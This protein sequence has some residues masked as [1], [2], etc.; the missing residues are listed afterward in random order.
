PVYGTAVVV[1]VLAALAI[2]L[3]IPPL[4][5]HFR[6]RNIA[7]GSLVL[8]LLFLNLAI[9]VNAIL[10]PT[11]DISIWWT[12][13]G[14]CD[15]EVY[16]FVGSWIGVVGAIACILRGLANVLD[17]KNT[18]VTTSKN[19]RRRKYAMEITVCFGL[20]VIQMAL[21]YIVQPIRYFIYGISGCTPAADNSWPSIVLVALPPV[22]V[23][24]VCAFYACLVLYRLYRYRIDF[25]RL[26][27][28]SNTTRSRFLRL[29]L[30][31]CTLIIGILPVA[32]YMFYYTAVHISMDGIVPYSWSRVH[33]EHW[34]SVLLIPMGGAV[35]PD[36]WCWIGAGIGVFAFFGTGS[37]A[38]D[39][40][41]AWLRRLGFAY[42]MPCLF[43]SRRGSGS[44][45]HS[46]TTT[47][48]RRSSGGN[49]SWTTSVRDRAKSVF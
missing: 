3:D 40:Y 11:D 39:M 28:A 4:V 35:Y 2:L 16:M 15:I 47:S 7:A 38:A 17:T 20:P 34:N 23:C 19:D 31:S 41:R 45:N 48:R 46:A 5:W 8:W 27:A 32:V 6:N 33:G 14:L 10:W 21:Y 9:F 29:F 24:L 18:V 37:E 30:M 43:R 42:C 44:G 49:A 1:A 12:G 25:S 36:R 26:L 22:L 13:S